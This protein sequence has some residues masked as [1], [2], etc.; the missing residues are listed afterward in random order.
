VGRYLVEDLST[1]GAVLTGN[2]LVP[3]RRPVR[4]QLPVPGCETLSLRARVV[5][6]QQDA[7]ERVA[8]AVVFQHL[9]PTAEDAIQDAVVAA[10]EMAERRERA[11]ILVVEDSGEL[12]RRIADDLHTLGMRV[13]VAPTALDAIRLLDEPRLDIGAVAIDAELGDCGAME[14]LGFLQDWYPQVRRVLVRSGIAS[15]LAVLPQA[16]GMADVVVN[17]PW[18]RQTL[19]AALA[20][21]PGPDGPD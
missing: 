11:A 12:S 14:L 1:E 17:R 5:R 20:V 10:L 2:A 13:F 8:L 6:Q 9:P 19:A 4:I 15:M 18:Q 21:G 7:W 16:S 3:R